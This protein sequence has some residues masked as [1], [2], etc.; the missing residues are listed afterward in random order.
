MKAEVKAKGKRQKLKGKSVDALRAKNCSLTSALCPL[1]FVFRAAACLL[2]FAFC[3]LTSDVSAQKRPKPALKQSEAKRVIAAT[4]GF[5]LRTGAVK[6]LEISPAG[7]EP[8]SVTAEVKEALRLA[9]VEDESVPQTGGVFKQKRWRALEFRTGDRSWEEFDS[10]TG[11]AGADRVESARR[12]IE[13]LVTEYDARVR[14]SKGKAVKPLTR[15]PLTI[16]Q[17]SAMGSNAVAEVV[18]ATTFHLSKDARG[19]WRVSEVVFG[20]ET[21]GELD[22]LWQRVNARKAALA[23]TDLA[24]LRDALEAFRAERGFYVVARD[25]V[26]LLDHLNP[27]Y[28]KHVIRIDP[29]HNPYRYEGTTAAYTLASD[30]PDGKP[31]TSD[32]VTLTR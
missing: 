15:G 23:R 24:T 19:R 26:V 7:T 1:P 10:L 6:V 16:K 11:A 31:N 25:S 29:W 20:G 8:V 4:P 28:L 14:E 18:V 3:L 12:A 13:G 30:G 2:P 9:W 22:S 17:L 32:D 5:S 21:F 27:R